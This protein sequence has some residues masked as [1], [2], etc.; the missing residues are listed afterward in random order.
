MAKEEGD[1]NIKG[2][3]GWSAKHAPGIAL[4]LGGGMARGFC[5]IGV[6]NV[7]QRNGITPSIVAGTSIGSVIGAAYLCGRLA[8]MEEW[9]LSLNRYKILSYLDVRVRSAGLIGGKRLNAILEKN[10][11]GIMI[12]DL[13]VPFITI[14]ADLVTGHEVWINKGSL[15]EA[16][17]ASFALPGVF[18]PVERNHRLLVDGALVNP[19]PVS[20]CQ[21]MGARM[22]IGVD[23][24]ADIIG[25]AAKPGQ[26]FQTVAG[27]DLFSDSDVP[28]E[29][30]K[31]VTSGLTKRLF[32]REENHPSLFGVMIS[33]LGIMQDRMTRSRLAGDPPDIHIKPQIGHIGLLEFEKAS[34]LIAEG[35]AAALRAMPD[36][37]AAMEVFLPAKY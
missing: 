21:A 15:I 33:A 12:E 29:Q 34:E 31:K 30:Q 13:P 4:A 9:A 7:L 24:H 25:K 3:S 16:M 26:N 2:K 6:L 22:T 36:I 17:Q 19:V 8:E 37:K 27:F 5:H 1:K 20:A 18:P 35:E 10:F 11:K 14:A 28:P 23:L 32:R